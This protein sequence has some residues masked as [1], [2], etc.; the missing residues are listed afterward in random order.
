MMDMN[1]A[2]VIIALFVA[3]ALC[4]ITFVEMSAQR[5]LGY[6]AWVFDR[7]PR[8]AR[9]FIH[10]DFGLAFLFLLMLL[11]GYVPMPPIVLYLGILFGIVCLAKFVLAAAMLMVMEVVRIREIRQSLG[12]NPLSTEILPQ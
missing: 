3:A 10:A 8:W 11:S 9:E 4:G 6:R 12:T 1:K 5:A 7:L 2:I